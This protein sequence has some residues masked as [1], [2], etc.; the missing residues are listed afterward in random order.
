V[1]RIKQGVNLNVIKVTGEAYLY[2]K[3]CIE[4]RTHDLLIRTKVKDQRPF[5]V[6]KTGHDQP[7]A[8][9]TCLVTQYQ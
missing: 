4:D 8:G 7:S 3:E 2:K 5:Q 1:P 6:D 9:G